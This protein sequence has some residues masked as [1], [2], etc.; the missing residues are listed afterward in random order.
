MAYGSRPVTS[1]GGGPTAPGGILPPLS[2][3]P[4]RP[5]PTPAGNRG[6]AGGFSPPLP[7][8]FLRRAVGPDRPPEEEEEA[9]GGGGEKPPVR[10]ARPLTAPQALPVLSLAE[11]PG[12]LSLARLGLGGPSSKFSAMVAGWAVRGKAAEPV[13]VEKGAV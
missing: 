7:P 4:A 9:A 5:V 8:A 3:H 10:P 13:I 2:R 12:E 6:R 1:T 11:K